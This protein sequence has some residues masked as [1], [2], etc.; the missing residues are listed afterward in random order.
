MI[1]DYELSKGIMIQVF[2]QEKYNG[3]QCGQPENTEI[4]SAN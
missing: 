2:F 1:V 3:K 4:S